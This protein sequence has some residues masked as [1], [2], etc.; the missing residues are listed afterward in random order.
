M[1]NPYEAL[2]QA[3]EALRN[4][5]DSCGSVEFYGE[6][7]DEDCNDCAAVAA[8]AIIDAAL[9]AQGAG[10]ELEAL[11][12]ENERLKGELELHWRASKLVVGDRMRWARAWKRAAKSNREDFVQFYELNK[13]ADARAQAEKARAEALLRRVE[14][15]E[16]VLWRSGRI[17]R[18]LQE[19]K[20][21]PHR[22][23]G[24]GHC[25]AIAIALEAIEALSPPTTKA[26]MDAQ[27]KRAL[28]LIER[29]FASD[30]S[31]QNGEHDGLCERKRP[32]TTKADEK[33]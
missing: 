11:R 18:T 23:D 8:L 25:Q 22:E 3:R 13:D 5:P 31:C 1:T 4:F 24:C 6:D 14:E 9:A 21:S 19:R 30:C 32:P 26:D 7:P 27:A 20:H 17:F 28:G 15:L 10:G 2:R 16:G 12:A 29:T 33:K